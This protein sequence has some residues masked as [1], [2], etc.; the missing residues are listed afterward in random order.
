VIAS[1][2]GTSVPKTGAV[3]LP[4]DRITIMPNVD[5]LPTFNSD[6]RPNQP[7]TRQ[8]VTAMLAGREPNVVTARQTLARVRLPI[9]TSSENHPY[10]NAALPPKSTDALAVLRHDKTTDWAVQQVI[11]LEPSA[12]TAALSVTRIEVLPHAA[13]LAQLIDQ[14][15]LQVSKYATVTESGGTVLQGAADIPGL[16]INGMENSREWRVPNGFRIVGNMQF[17]AGITSWHA[18][19]FTVAPGVAMPK[20]ESPRHL[21]VTCETTKKALKPGEVCPWTN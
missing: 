11:E 8:A 15:V 9:G 14:G 12:V 2:H 4:N 13:G 16:K 10:E 3:G 20:N 7:R 18:S 21:T 17:P 19:S 5:C 6:L 1:S